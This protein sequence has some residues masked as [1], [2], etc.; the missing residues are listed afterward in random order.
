MKTIKLLLVSFLTII[1]ISVTGCKKEENPVTPPSE[2]FEPEGWV[3]RDETQK[4]VIVVFQ[5][6]ILKQFNGAAVSDTLYAPLNS[7]SPHYSVKFLD[8][9]KTII[10][11]P[12]D[13][14]HTLGWIISNSSLLE[15]HQ[16]SPGDWAFHLK[17][18]QLGQTDIEFQVLHMGHSDVITPKIPVVIK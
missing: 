12:S 10:N 2:H 5:G 11:P 4:P 13:D 9:D 18:I 7:L 15:V 1:L 14:D 3:V 16:D 8:A 17:G 6:T